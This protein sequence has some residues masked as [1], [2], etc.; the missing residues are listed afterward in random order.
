[1]LLWF[2]GCYRGECFRWSAGNTLSGWPRLDLVNPAGAF[3]CLWFRVVNPAR[4]SS[5]ITPALFSALVRS[6]NS[7]G[8]WFLLILRPTFMTFSDSQR[9]LLGWSGIDFASL[10]WYYLLRG[11]RARLPAPSLPRSAPALLFSGA[12][13]C[14]SYFWG[15]ASRMMRA[16]SEASFAVAST[17]LASVSSRAVNSAF[18]ISS[19]SSLPFLKPFS[20]PRTSW[21]AS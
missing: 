6:S 20:L 4:S 19:M 3:Y 17:S 13:R 5:R 15:M 10:S 7:S 14:F 2:R 21:V 8:S 1:M 18:V 11:R 9:V 12:S 16:A